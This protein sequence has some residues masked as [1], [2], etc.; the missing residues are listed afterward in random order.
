MGANTKAR[1]VVDRLCKIGV[2]QAW[3]IAGARA[4][5]AIRYLDLPS[6]RVLPVSGL[7][8]CAVSGT[9]RRGRSEETTIDL[10]E[11]RGM[12]S[13]R[14]H[15]TAGRHRHEWPFR[16]QIDLATRLIVPG[17]L[18]SA[19]NRVAEAKCSPCR[20]PP[21]HPLAVAA[22]VSSL[23]SPSCQQVLSGDSLAPRP[24]A[25]TSPHR[26]CLTLHSSSLRS[27]KPLLTIPPLT[28]PT[29]VAALLQD[30]AAA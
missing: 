13:Q 28:P 8:R 17:L 23:A 18:S 21:M 9:Y 20:P 19:M 25:G 16:D 22:L 6:V 3:L 2:I 12:K 27:T 24:I 10:T 29:R 5:T 1:G 11:T 26:K 4:G 14:R 7:H 15:R 30:R